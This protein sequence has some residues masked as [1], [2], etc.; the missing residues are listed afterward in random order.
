ML[1]TTMTG[2]FT[3]LVCFKCYY[4]YFLLFKIHIT[5]IKELIAFY[6]INLP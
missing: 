1:R 3:L 6:Y 5:L 2:N 4:K